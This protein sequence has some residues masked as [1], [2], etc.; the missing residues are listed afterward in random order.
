M[1]RTDVIIAKAHNK[2]AKREK[3]VLDEIAKMKRKGEKIT[4]YGV[5]KRTGAAK[6]FLYRNKAIRDAIEA[7]RASPTSRS[8]SSKDVLIKCQQS[9]ITD[10]EKENKRLK[11]ETSV[12]YKT[13]YDA[14][15]EENEALRKQLR[16]A[17]KW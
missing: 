2:S 10:L 14:L 5:Q 4:F 1:A 15:L 6:S 16:T 7:S 17:Y 9:R 13:K 12:S 8:P 11:A 3:E